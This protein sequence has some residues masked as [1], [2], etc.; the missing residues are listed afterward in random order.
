MYVLYIYIY[1]IYIYKY[2]LI[3]NVT[4]MMYLCS[5]YTQ[6]NLQGYY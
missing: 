5:S 4:K 6:D 3:H 2:V 1:I